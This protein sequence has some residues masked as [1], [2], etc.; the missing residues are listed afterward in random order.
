[1]EDKAQDYDFDYYLLA[2]EM[3]RAI[4][5]TGNVLIKVKELME[6]KQGPHEIFSNYVSDMHNLHF[7]LKHKIDIY[8]RYVGGERGL[9]RSHDPNTT[10]F[11][12][13]NGA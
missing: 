10:K 3:E 9:P 4:P 11:M 6:R 2:Q 5:T 7:K 13:A 8:S 12:P 1:M